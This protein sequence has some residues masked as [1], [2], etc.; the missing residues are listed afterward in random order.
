MVAQDWVDVTAA[1]QRTA[2][3]RAL[4]AKY[5]IKYETTAR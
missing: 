3:V 1:E 5:T 4:A 2:A